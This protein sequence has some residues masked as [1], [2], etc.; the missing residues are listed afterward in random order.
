[1]GCVEMT[2]RMCKNALVR[3]I[4]GTDV[5]IEE[6]LVECIDALTNGSDSRD[7]HRRLIRL[8]LDSPGIPEGTRSALVRLDER[9]CLHRPNNP[10]SMFS[11]VQESDA[12][13]CGIV[14]D[15]SPR[16]LPQYAYHGTTWGCLEGVLEHGLVPGKKPVWTGQSEE[17]LRVREHSDG[18]VFFADSWRSAMYSW[19]F[20]SHK[21]SRG[22]KISRKRIPAVIRLDAR[23][24]SLE[25][26]ALATARSWKVAGPVTA[27]DA[28]VI[29]GFDIGFPRWVPLRV[30]ASA[31]SGASTIGIRDS[32]V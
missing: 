31:T 4:D 19:A 11:T 9:F 22:P 12:F 20:I 2:P 18:G 14:D 1:M 15:L 8:A 3:C 21:R 27:L 32:A 13:R 23:N 16:V 5:S 7:E 10:W 26:D 6:L 25:A 17:S 30:A 24:L 29:I 28:E